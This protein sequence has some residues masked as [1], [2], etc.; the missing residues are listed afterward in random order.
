MPSSGQSVG[1][2]SVEFTP[3][4]ETG[5]YYVCYE[6]FDKGGNQDPIKS[7]RF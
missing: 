3:Q 2:D 4:V 6:S 5:S 7:R 1:T